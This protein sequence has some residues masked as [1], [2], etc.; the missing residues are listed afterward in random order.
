MKSIAL[1]DRG[2]VRVFLTKQFSK[3]AVD[4]A[5]DDNTL[6]DTA[7]KAF[8]GEVSADLG[9]YL[10]KQRVA[11]EDGGKSG[12][13][14]TILCFRKSNDSRIFFLHGFPK[15]NKGNITSKEE[16]ALKKIAKSLVDLSNEQ[17]EGLKAKMAI[18][19]LGNEDGKPQ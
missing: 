3:W 18:R 17:V 11:R 8:G 7:E 14:R 2:D 9:G 13:Y 4:E 5:I 10:F 12:G 16:K 6:F 19:E 1:S 15:S